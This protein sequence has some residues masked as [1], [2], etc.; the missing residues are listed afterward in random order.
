LPRS[1]ALP[2]NLL[3][4]R[5]NWPHSRAPFLAAP[6]PAVGGSLADIA[7]DQ[8][9]A[10]F[11]PKAD[12]AE[13]GANVRFVP[14]RTSA[15]G[16]HYLA[17]PIGSPKFM[18]VSLESMCAGRRPWTAMSNDQK[19]VPQVAFLKV[20]RRAARLGMWFLR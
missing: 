20:E 2:E 8:L 4:R 7:I 6:A 17:A 18:R 9:Q 13:H 1:R 3:M 11:T 14:K 15:S 19:W 10:C 16:N 12:I 5:R